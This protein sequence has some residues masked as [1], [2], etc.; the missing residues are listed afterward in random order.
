MPKPRIVQCLCGPFRHCLFGILYEPGVSSGYDVFGFGDGEEFTVTEAN[1]APLLTR[2]VDMLIDHQGINPWCGICHSPRA[3]W[4]FEDAPTKFETMDEALP[5]ARE[6]E[7]K[8]AAARML[9]GGRN[10]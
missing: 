2:L 9:L 7:R 6:E 5:A 1:A 8:Q 4:L 10:N 3:A